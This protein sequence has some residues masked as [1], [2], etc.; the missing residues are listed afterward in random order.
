MRINNF[1][2]NINL[3]DAD[4]RL[5]EDENGVDTACR[6]QADLLLA[7]FVTEV[8]VLEK[9]RVTI[10]HL[11]LAAGADIPENLLFPV[12]SRSEGSDP[13]HA[14]TQA[15]LIRSQGIVVAE[16]ATATAASNEVDAFIANANRLGRAAK[17]RRLSRELDEVGLSDTEDPVDEATLQAQRQAC[18][19]AI[20]SLVGSGSVTMEDLLEQ[21]IQSKNPANPNMRL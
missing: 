4:I 14:L 15:G 20:R 9:K 1:A 21:A 7:E 6:N 16:Q 13:P 10:L 8:S 18:C 12:Y 17:R 11:L 2:F 19:A 5:I 3:D